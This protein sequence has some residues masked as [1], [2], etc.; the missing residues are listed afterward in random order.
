[1]T[2]QCWSRYK[3]YEIEYDNL[4]YLEG[5]IDII[6]KIQLYDKIYIK[7]N[8]LFICGTIYK[9]FIT[10]D[11]YKNILFIVNIYNQIFSNVNKL[12]NSY[13]ENCVNDKK[14]KINYF[15]NLLFNGISGLQNLKNNYNDEIISVTIENLLFEIHNTIRYLV[16]IRNGLIIT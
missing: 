5:I 11:F 15:I 14:I 9:Y 10:E 13:F 1:M 3:K 12:T 7:Y 16:S 6:G 4:S 8:S 2:L